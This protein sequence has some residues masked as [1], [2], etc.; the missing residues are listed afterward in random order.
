MLI[1][2]PASPSLIA[3]QGASQQRRDRRLSR[4][5][6][7]I[8][9]F[10]HGASK[11]EIARNCGMGRRTVRRW[12]AAQ[13][14]PV[15][16]PVDRLSSVDQHRLYLEQRWEQGCHNAAQL[17]RELPGERV[18]RSICDCPQVDTEALWIKGP[19][20]KA[21]V[22]AIFVGACVAAANR[23]VVLERTGRRTVLSRRGSQPVA[24]DYHSRHVDSGVPPHNSQTGCQC[25]A[26]VVHQ[27]QE[28]PAGQ[29]RKVPLLGRGC[30]TGS[31]TAALEQRSGGRKYSS[32]ETNQALHVRPREV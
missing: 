4:Y 5:Q 3:R 27:R 29:L 15:G 31:I 19:P 30:C 9:L 20:W 22:A 18:C 17:W 13:Q 10:R 23:L 6:E 28:Q 21:C 25:L 14:F 16:K 8:E 12:I 24:G 7:V 11:N 2:A 1:P 26:T 32:A